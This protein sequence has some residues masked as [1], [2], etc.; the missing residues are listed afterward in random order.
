MRRLATWTVGLAFA[1]GLLGLDALGVVATA[2]ATFVLAFAFRYAPWRWAVL[3][4]TAWAAGA[5]V[6]LLLTLLE[7]GHGFATRSQ[8]DAGV[9]VL[10]AFASAFAGAW[11]SWIASRLARQQ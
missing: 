1:A 9:M 8:A 5:A 7:G 4:L 6:G 3:S 11:L 10:A 2:L